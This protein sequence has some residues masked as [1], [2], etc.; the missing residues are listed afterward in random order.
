M[1]RME[2]NSK[3]LYIEIAILCIFIISLPSTEAIKNISWLIYTTIWLVSRLMSH[4]WGEWDKWDTIFALWLP[5]GLIVAA[6]SNQGLQEWD[7][8]NDLLRYI[9]IGWM[10]YR[11]RYSSKIITFLATLIII[12]T[13]ISLAHGYWNWQIAHNKSA[14]MLKS[15]GHVNHSAIYLAISAGL[16]TSILTAFWRKVGHIVWLLLLAAAAILVWATLITSSR[17]AMV[18]MLILFPLAGILLWQRSRYILIVSVSI[19]IGTSSLA[20]QQDLHIVGKT[21][22][23]FANHSIGQRNLTVNTGLLIW[24]SYPIAGVGLENYSTFDRPE[25]L[26]QLSIDIDGNYDSSKYIASMG[27]AHNIYAN[28]LAERGIIGFLPLLVVML[29]WGHY[30]YRRRP[31]KTTSAITSATWGGS[32]SA[33]VLSFVG[34]LFNTTMHHE[35]AILSV[36]LLVLWL[37]MLKNDDKSETQEDAIES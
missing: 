32:L 21:I 37:S 7:G 13:M 35:H 5:S 18:P 2:R 27:H 20:I 24:R 34:G 36:L 26:K 28:T 15:V 6:I 33:W 3:S 12:S 22:S 19:I 29:Y 8:A 11:A 17:G 25:K 16:A 10:V 4:D 23:I 9:G 1:E 31:T 30:L 14:L